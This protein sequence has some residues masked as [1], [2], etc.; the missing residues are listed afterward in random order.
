MLD[1]EITLPFPPRRIVSLVPSQTELLHH[2]GLEKETIGITK[3]CVHPKKWHQNKT[4]VG[5]TKQYDF[6]KIEAL[7][8]DLIIANKEENDRD[9]IER[10]AKQYPVWVSDVPH[11]AA[12]Y[13]MIERVG[14]LTDRKEVATDLASRLQTNFDRLKHATLEPKRAAYFIWQNPLMV[15]GGGTFI[16]AVMRAG[17]FV[18]VFADRARYPEISDA[19][20][21]RAAP[22]TILLSSEPFPFKERHRAYFHDLCPAADIILA[23]GELF[24][25]YGPRLLQT[26][27]Y[28]RRL[29]GD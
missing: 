5:G 28:L 26:A 12:A 17:G 25:W 27:D 1:R 6:D 10:L 9:Q 11:L 23:N 8:P 2:L 29:R 24:S 19:E 21:R 3:F 20:L 7:Q 22:E 4:R 14:R 18:N 13:D 16:D 15:A